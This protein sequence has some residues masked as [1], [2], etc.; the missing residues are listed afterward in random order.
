MYKLPEIGSGI[1]QF[2][3]VLANAAIQ[4]PFLI[5]IDEPELNLHPSLQLDFLTTLGSYASGG[6]LYSTH[7]IG[8][9]RAVADRIYSVRKISEGHSHVSIYEETPAL[10]EFLG[11]L[12]YSG[13]KELGF[14]PVL[15]VEGTS[16]VKTIQQ[17]LRLFKTDHE[18]VLLP[19]GVVV[20]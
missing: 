17:F 11:E 3:L 8:L 16:E 12:N 10:S 14:D 15:L 5:L 4:E 18:I 13:Y 20:D 7:S 2:I 6:V 19:R 9:A 1:T